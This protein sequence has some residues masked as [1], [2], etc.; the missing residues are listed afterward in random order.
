M[1]ESLIERFKDMNPTRLFSLGA[2]VVI[3]I[4]ALIV[5]VLWLNK[6]EFQVLYSNLSEDDAARVVEKLRDENI[7]FEIGSGG[8]ISVPAETVH[9]TRLKIASAGLPKGAGVGFEIFD[10]AGFGVTEFVQKVNY[11]RALQGELART[12]SVL[13]EVDTARVQYCYSEEEALCL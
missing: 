7:E 3:L 4:S 1:L 12:I 6:T 5:F 9:E 11:T 2:L 10:N 8:V 13:N